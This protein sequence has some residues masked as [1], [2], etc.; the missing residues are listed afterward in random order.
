MGERLGIVGGNGSGK[1]S[2]IKAIGGVYPIDAGTIALKGRVHGVFDLTTGF[3]LEDTGRNNIYHRGLLLGHSRREL[4]SLEAEIIEF[5]GL[6]EFIDLPMKLY[7][8]GMLVR[9]AYSVSTLVEGEILLIDEIFGA[10]DKAFREKAKRRLLS[11]LSKAHCVLFVSH[12]LDT[13]R[14]LCSRAIW[15]AAGRIAS[16]GSPQEVIADYL[17]HSASTG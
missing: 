5:A 2:L 16:E 9:L 14:E 11:M 13:V 17:R 3:N 1:S 10:G 12:D 15:M 6:G 4:K 8:A 7:S